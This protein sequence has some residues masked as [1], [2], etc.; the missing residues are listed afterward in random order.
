MVKYQ[1]R[2]FEVIAILLMLVASPLSVTY[3]FGENDSNLEEHRG[4]LT[5]KVVDGKLKVNHYALPDVLSEADLQRTLSIDDQMSWAYVNY[6]SYNAGIVLFD[7]KAS[8]L[9]ENLWEIS[10]NE[11]ILDEEI[12]FQVVFS[13][14]TTESDEE[15]VFAVSLVNSMIKN[16]ETDQSLRLLQIG[17][18]IINSIDSNQ[19]YR[20]SIR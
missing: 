5:E 17:E 20:N 10:M 6:E 18:P 4:I 19:E 2:N 8:K 7:G 11:N 1:I 15:N 16:P 14:K 9:G 13:G 12:S 3:A